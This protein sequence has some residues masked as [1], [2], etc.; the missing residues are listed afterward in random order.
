MCG[1][2]TLT[3]SAAEVARHFGLDAV[4]D[5]HPRFNVAPTQDVA[6]VRARRPA[7]SPGLEFRHWGLV[8]HWAPDRAGAARRINARA[9][10]AAEKP[11]FRDALRSRRCLVPMDGYFEWK[12]SGR[13]KRPHHVRLAQGEL[14][15]VAGLYEDW[16]GPGG[17]AL[18][19]VTLLT[20]AASPGLRALHPRMPVVVPLGAYTAWLDPDDVEGAAALAAIDPALGRTLTVR[21]VSD[22][23]NDARHDGPECLAAPAA[24]QG[25]LFDGSGA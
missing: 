25:S 10:T 13:R 22:H 7:G 14:F 20:Q 9:E 16:R 17:E 2:F 12:T 24:V 19:S 4:P 21:E 15:A 3:T 6:T 5:L 1:R 11:S 23:V 8:P 18:S